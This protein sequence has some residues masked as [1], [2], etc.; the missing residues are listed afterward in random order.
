M[1]SILTSMTL[2]MRSRSNLKLHL[3]EGSHIMGGWSHNVIP[4]YA[5]LGI[6]TDLKELCQFD[7]YF[8]L[9]DLRNE[10]KVKFI[11]FIW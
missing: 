4:K 6:F 9:Y 7:L 10:V 11:N 5:P 3:V 2:E 1:T 8:D